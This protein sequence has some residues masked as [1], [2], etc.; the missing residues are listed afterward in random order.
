MPPLKEPVC[1]SDDPGFGVTQPRRALKS[2][3]RKNGR[4]ENPPNIS[5][6]VRLPSFGIRRRGL[7]FKRGKIRL[8]VY[9]RFA[10]LSNQNSQ[11]SKFSEFSK[12]K[13]SATRCTCGTS[14]FR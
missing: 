7:S 14:P 10:R 12:S 8:L 2:Q 11:Q 13:F 4:S 9:S 5:I 3:C 6:L 1:V